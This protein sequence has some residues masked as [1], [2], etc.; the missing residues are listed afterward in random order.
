MSGPEL[1][2][3]GI[4]AAPR[5]TAGCQPACVMLWCP[6]RLYSCLK[7]VTDGTLAPMSLQI[8]P[9]YAHRSMALRYIV[10]YDWLVYH[11]REKLKLR[12]SEMFIARSAV[13]E[14]ASQAG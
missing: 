4:Y 11:G 12:G 13:A 14:I 7:G 3:L 6:L 1:R 2:L 10:H 5:H 9:K 8:P